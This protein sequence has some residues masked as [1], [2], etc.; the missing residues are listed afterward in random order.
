[1]TDCT[2]NGKPITPGNGRE[3]NP[4]AGPVE[5]RDGTLPDP[6]VAQAAGTQ[7]PER[8]GAP[9]AMPGQHRQTVERPANSCMGESHAGRQQCISGAEWEKG[10]WNRLVPGAFVVFVLAGKLVPGALGGIRTPNL[11]IRSQMLYPLSHE[12]L[13]ASSTLLHCPEGRPTEAETSV[14]MS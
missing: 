12:R 7:L 13:K 11:L 6:D 9:S 3:P 5:A 14:A 10:P 8:C 4:L 2:R 1:M